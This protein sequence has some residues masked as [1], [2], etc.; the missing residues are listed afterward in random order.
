MVSEF[1][2]L[3]INNCVT[4][5]QLL[6][7]YVYHNDDV[8]EGTYVDTSRASLASIYIH[9]YQSTIDM[10]D[11]N[12]AKFSTTELPIPSDVILSY[13]ACAIYCQTF[14]LSKIM[15]PLTISPLWILKK[16]MPI[17]VNRLP[18]YILRSLN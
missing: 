8:S 17:V 11:E 1:K 9:L 2:R 13:F 12:V 7:Y 10:E 5:N 16:L 6:N 14:L 15:L 3:A 18:K 4:T